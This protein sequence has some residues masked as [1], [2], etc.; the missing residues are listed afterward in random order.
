M[1]GATIKTIRK[2]VQNFYYLFVV[3]VVVV[4]NKTSK[5]DKVSGHFASSNILKLVK[6]ITYDVSG[7]G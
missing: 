5:T 3:V 7:T 2:R 1:H 4:K 6:L